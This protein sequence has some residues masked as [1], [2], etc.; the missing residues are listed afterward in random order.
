MQCVFYNWDELKDICRPGQL[1][2]ASYYSQNYP[3][4]D[5]KLTEDSISYLEQNDCDFTFL[6][7][8]ETDH[9][10]HEYGWMNQ[11]YLDTAAAAFG[12]VEMVYRR[13]WQEYTILITADHGGHDRIHGTNMPED[14][15]IPLFIAGGKARVFAKHPTILDIAPTI[16]KILG[17]P[18]CDEW[19]G[20]ALL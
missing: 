4:T 16:V 19:E 14:M 9:A 18:S 15:T 11:A 20:H 1:F 8:G 2:R 3:D 7:L 10:G 12:C 6:Y 5:R 13:F 17:V